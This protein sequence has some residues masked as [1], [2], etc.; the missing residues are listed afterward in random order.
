MVTITTLK[1][2]SITYTTLEYTYSGP[3]IWG[4]HG[5]EAGSSV[6]NK[7]VTTLNKV[8]ELCICILTYS[9]TKVCI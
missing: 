5:A 3:F 8:T 1:N 2:L 4:I 7:F 6:S 9:H